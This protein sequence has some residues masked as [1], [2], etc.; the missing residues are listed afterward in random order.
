MKI[1]PPDILKIWL[2]ISGFAAFTLWLG[3]EGYDIRA[4]SY[5][6]INHYIY[7]PPGYPLFLDLSRLVFGTNYLFFVSFMQIAAVLAAAWWCARELK[8]RFALA[9]WQ[10]GIVFA[11]L[12]LPLFDTPVMEGGIGNAILTEAFA[13]SAFLICAGLLA[14]AAKT[15][16]GLTALTVLMTAATL[17][18]PQLAFIW[19][20]AG[21]AVWLY[22]RKM[23][24]KT[25]ALFFTCFILCSTGERL[26][27]LAVNGYFAKMS[28]VPHH[29][30]A[31]LLYF[32]DENALSR[33]PLPDREPA[34]AVYRDMAAKKLV[35]ANFLEPIPAIAERT[36]FNDIC[37]G[38]M[39]DVYPENF[40]PKGEKNPGCYIMLA[41]F[42]RRVIFALGP[43]FGREILETSLA[44][45]FGAA[46]WLTL[47]FCAGFAGAVFII[48]NRAVTALFALSALMLLTNCAMTEIL[49]D[50]ATRLYLYSDALEL[51]LFALAACL[52]LTRRAK[53]I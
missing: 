38:T 35:A 16:A 26:Y 44:A 21:A 12:I 28:V 4:D 5:E 50:G 41:D 29:M 18:K 48:K 30:A 43:V 33:L 36:A 13:Y 32:A 46:N 1:P 52:V 47:L 17:I 14:R 15:G 37:W 53:Q 23:F 42:S 10:T 31:K 40:C 45:M 39:A 2:G 3:F 6:Y 51:A 24:T 9:R 20:A 34:L 22:N 49:S 19:P 11:T 7:R 25:A 27:H 8:M